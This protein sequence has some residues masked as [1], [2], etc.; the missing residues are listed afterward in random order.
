MSVGDFGCEFDGGMAAVEVGNK[1]VQ[2]FFPV[3]SNH[4]DIVYVPF[5]N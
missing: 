1:F 3:E 2:L 5:P 4:K